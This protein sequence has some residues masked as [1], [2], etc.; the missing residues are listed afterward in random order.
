[1]RRDRIV[2]LAVSAL[3]LAAAVF[4][5]P[6]RQE[7][8]SAAPLERLTLVADPHYIAPELTDGGTYFTRIVENGDGKAMPYCEEIAR[9]EGRR[10]QRKQKETGPVSRVLMLF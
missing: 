4:L 7:N 2:F 6:H 10:T 9:P 5:V 1:M 8:V 3:V